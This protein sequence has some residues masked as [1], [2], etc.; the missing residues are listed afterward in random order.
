MP[1]AIRNPRN[2]ILQALL[3]TNATWTELLNETGLS[4]GALSKYLE[5]LTKEGL[6]K[7]DVDASERPPRVRYSI[8]SLPKETIETAVEKIDLEEY[9]GKLVQFASQSG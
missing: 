2:A 9:Y 5:P 6:V 8:V 3:K 4:K 1:K 7:R